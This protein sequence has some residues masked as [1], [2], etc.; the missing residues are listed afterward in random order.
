MGSFS[1]RKRSCSSTPHCPRPSASPRGASRMCTRWCGS[2]RCSRRVGYAPTLPRGGPAGRRP[3]RAEAVR[4][5]GVIELGAGIGLVGILAAAMGASSV[6]L[7]DIGDAL[8]LLRTN[9]AANP[10]ADCDLFVERL[11]W[12]D[13]A[14]AARV[15]GLCG[16]VDLILGADVVYNQPEAELLALACAVDAL[17]CGAGRGARFALAYGHRGDWM[18]NVAFFDEMQRLG[19]DAEQSSLEQYADRPTDDF[20]L[21]TFTHSSDAPALRSLALRD[22]DGDLW[23]LTEDRGQRPPALRLRVNGEPRPRCLLVRRHGPAVLC[24]LPAVADAVRTLVAADPAEAAAAG[25][26]AR[27]LGLG[28]CDCPAAEALGG[29]RVRVAAATDADL[30]GAGGAGP[31]AEEGC[32]GAVA[33]VAPEAEGQVAVLL[34][35]QTQPC[36]L[37][38]DCVE[39]SGA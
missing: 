21:Y 5:R 11:F 20:L 25:E 19:Y 2:A 7:T 26:L 23:E 16:G 27:E 24:L 9:V 22:V 8:P 12:G 4:G 32:G 6:V 30:V 28:V 10:V 33:A 13:A 31:R 35:G 39:L 29:R 1:A 34:D 14:D 37:W 15:L 17:R 38:L 3:R 36:W 18:S